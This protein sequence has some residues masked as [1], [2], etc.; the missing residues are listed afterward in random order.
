MAAKCG[1]HD[2]IVLGLMKRSLCLLYWV[3]AAEAVGDA[4]QMFQQ[5]TGS[6]NVPSFFQYVTDNV[7]INGW[8]TAGLYIFGQD[9]CSSS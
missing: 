6:V 7:I 9:E 1:R 8:C 5:R 2:T 4:V 3:F